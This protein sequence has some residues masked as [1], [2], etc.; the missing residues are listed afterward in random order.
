MVSTPV[1]SV[2]ILRAAR[3][4]RQEGRRV[5][6][7]TVVRT[8]GSSPRPIGSMLAVDE[9]FDMLGSVS[10]GCVEGVT[11]AAAVEIIRTGGSR[12]LTFDVSREQGLDV[13][14]S[15]AGR[16]EVCIE[17]FD[18]LDDPLSCDVVDSVL[19]HHD[20]DRGAVL[21]CRLADRKRT[22]VTED[23][24]SA[25]GDAA[26]VAMT[27]DRSE[28]VAVEGEPWLLQVFMPPRRL[29]V[30]GA[31]D[32]AQALSVMA[33]SI[34]YAVIVLDPRSAFA[35]EKRFPGME[36]L[37][38]WPDKGLDALGLGS[39]TAVI[40]LSHD[41]KLD[42]PALARA[43][44]SEVFYVGALGSRRTHANRMER[45]RQSGLA[46]EALSRIRAP[47]GLNIGAREPAE[48]A[49]AILAEIVQTARQ[50]GTH[51]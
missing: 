1:Q 25:L 8:W 3:T 32:I 51:S 40:T 44:A 16:I 43:L 27:A 13:G 47:I 22:T 39:R 18:E 26:R 50:P 14:L 34:G 17:R 21:A 29:V 28:T 12:V 10:G 11:A 45:L 42:D 48:I 6:L 7:A 30:I 5:A 46:Q 33:S 36:I 19:G 38:V 4:W 15:C 31:S 41:P 24:C 37:P 35:S 9:N 23:D 2:A 49:L 20:A